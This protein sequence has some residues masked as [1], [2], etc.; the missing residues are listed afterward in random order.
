MANHGC[1]LLLALVAAV[2]AA[3]LSP[4]P[5]LHPPF[6][7]L[8]LVELAVQRGLTLPPRAPLKDLKLNVPVGDAATGARAFPFGMAD[9]QPPQRSRQRKL[10]ATAARAKR[11]TDDIYDETLLPTNVVPTRYT[12]RQQSEGILEDQGKVPWW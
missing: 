5:P 3:P 9:P 1:A 7:D 6:S 10:E 4:L 12:V 8:P 2:S 11:A